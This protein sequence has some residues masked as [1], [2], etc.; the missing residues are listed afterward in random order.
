VVD[1][2]S[3]KTFKVRQDQALG[4]LTE[5]WMSLHCRGAGLDGPQKSLPTLRIL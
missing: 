1:A 2:L 3:L 4:N 5:L